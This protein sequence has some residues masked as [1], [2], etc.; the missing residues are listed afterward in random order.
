M[1]VSVRVVAAGMEKVIG[2]QFILKMERI[3]PAINLN[4]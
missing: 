3:E 2:S 4:V 1:V